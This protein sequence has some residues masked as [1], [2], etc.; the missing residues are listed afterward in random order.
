MNAMINYGIEE[1][2]IAISNQLDYILLLS[3]HV[4]RGRLILEFFPIY[5]NSNTPTGQQFQPRMRLEF[6]FLPPP[7]KNKIDPRPLL[8]HITICDLLIVVCVCVFLPCV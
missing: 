5:S 4:Q 8:A 3:Y 7:R 1:D 6:P 2:K